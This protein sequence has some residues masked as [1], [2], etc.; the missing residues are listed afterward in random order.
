MPV[1]FMETLERIKM[2]REMRLYY[3]ARRKPIHVL[4]SPVKE[5]ALLLVRLA[6][7]FQR[8]TLNFVNI[9]NKWMDEW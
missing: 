9:L 1:I 8:I 2:I 4:L 6:D 3:H 5:F 7:R